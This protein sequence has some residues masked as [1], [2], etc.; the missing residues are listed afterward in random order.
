MQSKIIKHYKLLSDFNFILVENMGI[1]EAKKDDVVIT[2][3]NDLFIKEPGSIKS[4]PT[5]FKSTSVKSIKINPILF[6]EIYL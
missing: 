5:Y 4:V 6:E 3:D 2:I 1:I